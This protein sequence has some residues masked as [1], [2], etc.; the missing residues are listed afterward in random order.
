MALRL[1]IEA[2]T[3]Q[4]HG[5]V[6]VYVKNFATGSEVDIGNASTQLFP[7][8]S[9]IKIP[10]LI[11]MFQKIASGELSFDQIMTYSESRAYPG[12][13]IFQFFKDGTQIELK[14]LLF[15]MIAFSDNVA[16][17]WNQ[18]L[19][20]GGVQINKIMESMGFNNT[21]VNSRT[22]GREDDYNKYGWG[23][24]TAKEIA[25]IISKVRQGDIRFPYNKQLS[26]TQN[27]ELHV[28]LV[29]EM[30]RLLGNHFYDTG[31]ISQI[32]P[33][34]KT[35]SKTGSLDAVRSEVVYVNAPQ[36]EYVFSILTQDNEDQSWDDDNNEAEVM[37]RN[38]SKLIW[39]YYQGK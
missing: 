30:Y 8:A 27:E 4:F 36:Q 5:R 18:E 26:F 33:H 14:M 3:K 35:A 19:A 39:E 24:T 34:I 13:G 28:E 25:D 16:S 31:A 10:I 23:Q 32:P 20:G 1:Q 17:I 9:I 38:I 6:A 37:I 11:G 29:N 15:C 7:T 21:R 12:A 22:P 2:I